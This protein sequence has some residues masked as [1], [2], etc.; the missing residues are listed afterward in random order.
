MEQTRFFELMEAYD[1]EYLK[2]DRVENKLCGRPD[3][4]A[5][6]LLDRLVPGNRD[7]ISA[8]EHDQYY[9]D[10]DIDDLIQVI[11]EDQVV[12]LKRCGISYDAEYDC[13]YSFT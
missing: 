10:I 5:F 9:L 4:H 1:G 12:E 11:T 6:L 3:I 13:L 2:F 7:I 8:S